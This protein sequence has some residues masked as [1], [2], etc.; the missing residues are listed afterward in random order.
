MSERRAMEFYSG[1]KPTWYFIKTIYYLK[2]PKQENN[3]ENNNFLEM[4]FVMKFCLP[5]VKD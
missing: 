1:P 5:F 3:S 2:K 4:C